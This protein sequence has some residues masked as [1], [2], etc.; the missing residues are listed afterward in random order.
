MVVEQIK[1]STSINFVHRNGYR[2]ISLIILPVVDA[3]L[4]QVLYR[5]ILQALHSVCLAGPSLTV[6]ENGDC[7]RVEDE[8]ENGVHRVVVQ[9][10]RRLI[11]VKCVVKFKLLIVNVF[12]DAVNFVFAIVHNQIRI[13][14]RH[15]VYF[16]VGQLVLKDWSFLYTD[17][18]FELICRNVL[19]IKKGGVN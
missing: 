18:N 17:A 15:N 5:Q 9:L 19:F 1:N 14:T 12:G 3:A 8:V 11:M 6:G 13:R 2:K 4:K 7:S 16:A 10:L